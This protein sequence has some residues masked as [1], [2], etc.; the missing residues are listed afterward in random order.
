M[1]SDNEKTFAQDEISNLKDRADLETLFRLSNVLSSITDLQTLLENLV[2]LAI[3]NLNAERGVAFLIDK[4]GGLYPTAARSLYPEDIVDAH[5]IALTVVKEVVKGKNEF[6]SA[7]VSEDTTI[8][9]ESAVFFNILSVLCVPIIYQ[10]KVLG[11]LYLDHGKKAGAF[12]ERDSNFLKAFVKLSAPLI[13][14]IIEKETLS[15]S[16]SI[17]EEQRFEKEYPEIITNS[18]QMI[19]DF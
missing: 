8:R 9:S 15:V 12:S 10:E 7:N 5:K 17:V 6:L 14:H 18:Q 3:E 2:E 11:A 13:Y 19:P 1:S 4:A 16:S